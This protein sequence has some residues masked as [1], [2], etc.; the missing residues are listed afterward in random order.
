MLSFILCFCVVRRIDGSGGK[1][2]YWEHQDSHVT[3]KFPYFIIISWKK[4]NHENTR[5]NPN[6]SVH[7]PRTSRTSQPKTARPGGVT[8]FFESWE[9][10]W[11]S[12]ADFILK[13]HEFLFF[14]QDLI[15]ARRKAPRKRWCF[16]GFGNLRSS[17]KT[18]CSWAKSALYV[19]LKPL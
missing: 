17:W 18:C 1:C 13:F 10:S 3:A 19:S 12:R 9:K 15:T 5:Q 4:Q 11:I 2:D 7:V 16:L 8:I 6:K 14:F